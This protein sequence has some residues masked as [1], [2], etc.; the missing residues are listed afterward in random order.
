MKRWKISTRLHG[1]T[2]QKTAILIFLVSYRL[3]IFIPVTYYERKTASFRFFFADR[4]LSYK[5]EAPILGCWWAISTILLSG[6]LLYL[7]RYFTN[8]H[9]YWRK[10][11]IP[12]VKPI[13]LFGNFL[14]TVLTKKTLGEN[15]QDIYR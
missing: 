13:P 10:R 8:S 3:A 14:D 7:Y 6:G 2:T 9:D 11:S 1:T 5:M 12:Y 4:A 15:F